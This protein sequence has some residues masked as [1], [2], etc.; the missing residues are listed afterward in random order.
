MARSAQQDDR[1]RRLV[2]EGYCRNCLKRV[3]TPGPRGGSGLCDICRASDK[4]RPSRKR[5][6]EY[7]RSRREKFL[8]ESRCRYCGGV[9]TM[10]PKGATTMC[11]TCREKWEATRSDRRARIR[12]VAL[13]GGKCQDCGVE[14]VR[15][16]QFHHINGGGRQAALTRGEKE[17]TRMVR[18]IA[19]SGERDPELALVCANCHLI[20]HWS[21][22]WEP[23]WFRVSG[24]D[25]LY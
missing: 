24:S 14:D 23:E 6:M 10:G 11:Q 20:R 5:Q 25:K 2:A 18:L 22:R 12:A 9:P 13:Y 15:V 8:L 4:H 16:L 1:R 19:R 21:T 3:A 7:N 17:G